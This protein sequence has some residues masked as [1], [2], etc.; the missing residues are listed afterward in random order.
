MVQ[1]T[2]VNESL[3]I[4]DDTKTVVFIAK[5][6]V[7]AI[8]QSLYQAVPTADIYNL[9]LGYLGLVFTRRLSECLDPSGNVFTVNSFITFV[10]TYLGFNS[11]GIPQTITVV[12]NYSALPDPTT[13]S[14]EFYWCEEADGIYPIGLYYSDGVAWQYPSGGGGSQNLQ[15]VVNVGNGISNYGGTGTASMQ[16][17]NFVNNRTLYLNN[18]S[19]PTIKFEDN[20]DGTHYATLDIDTLNLSGVVYNWSNI[21]AQDLQSVTDNGD[22]TTNSIEASSFI[23]TG[24][25]SSEIL[26]ADGSIITA[27]ANISINGGLISAVSSSSGGNTVNFYLN[28]SVPSSVA[29]YYQI[30]STPILGVGTNFTKTGNG[31]IAQFLTDIGSPNRLDIPA[32]AWNFEMY[33]NMSS[34]GGT[35]E[36]YID[37]LKY[38]GSTFTTISSGIL[39]PEFIS[40]G[41]IVD[42][43]ITSLAVPQTTLLSTDRFAVRVYIVNNSGGRTATLHTENGNLCE[44]ITS[45]AGGIS[46]LNGLTATTQNFATSTSGTDFSIVSS[47]STHTFDMPS[48]SATAR[49]LVTTGTQT[50]VGVKTF[51]NGINVALSGVKGD[52]DIQSPNNLFSTDGSY[53]DISSALNLKQDT[54][55]SGTNIRTVN[56]STLL[57]STNLSVGTVTSVSALTLGTTGTD[58]SSTVATGTTTPVITLNV[59]DASA[60]ARG[61]VTTGSQTFAGTKTFSGLVVSGQTANTIA[62]FDNSKNLL[63]LSTSTYPS[64]TELSYVKGVTSAIQ[65]QI[66][67]KATNTIIVTSGTSFTTPATITA[68]TIFIIELVGAGGGG[69]GGLAAGNGSGGGGGGYVYK[70]ITGLTASTT[71]TCAI[72]V[73]GSAGASAGSGTA[74]TST[75]LTIGITTYTASGGGFG[76][77]TAS[78]LGGVGGS[79]TNGDINISGQNGNASGQASNLQTGG[80]GG[81][82]PKGWG[83]GGSGTGISTAGLAGTGFGG[84]GSAGHG[85]GVVGGAG[86][87]GIIYCTYYN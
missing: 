27:G 56:G 23:K 29:T 5:K 85:T 26:M 80:F 35:P 54:L 18:D 74:G 48:A 24:G 78:S 33:F 2:I 59:P 19:N 10:E 3:K 70:K 25:T 43:Y 1:F 60:T 14:G 72:G 52:P 76:L 28:G 32:G 30:S 53:Y 84:A 41:T 83:L 21:V 66:D 13:V 36:F 8:S 15:Q 4:V 16:S 63:S 45:F 39:N 38:N 11:G 50:I 37:L 55:V 82:S 69:G 34:N 65:T 61:V 12:L 40:G 6:D 67:S 77:G 75:T 44:I 64:L 22:S 68:S 20:L 87:N 58:L 31:L 57:G 79:G 7:F 86:T 42:V 47:G 9:N 51:N 49:G 81:N 17:T 62:S 73:G 46:A 71:Y